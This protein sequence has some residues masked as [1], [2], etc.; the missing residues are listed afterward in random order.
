[1]DEQLT[2]INRQFPW[3]H[4]A[5]AVFE[6]AFKASHALQSRVA[7]TA[8]ERCAS[9]QT[10]AL[11]SEAQANV[12]SAYASELLPAILGGSWKQTDSTVWSPGLMRRP[13]YSDYHGIFDHPV[14]FRRR[15]AKGP[16]TWKN[17][18]ILGRPYGLFDD[19][20]SVNPRHRDLAVHLSAREDVGVWARA[21]LS[22]WFPGWTSLVVAARGLRAAD[23]PRFGLIPPPPRFGQGESRSSGNCR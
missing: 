7:A 4:A 23:A 20:G 14:Q 10:R 19:D 3:V 9:R 16:S 13:V 2:T 17:W 1:M 15:G 12:V 18:I 22:A 11:A 8:Q 5:M 6:P 21:D